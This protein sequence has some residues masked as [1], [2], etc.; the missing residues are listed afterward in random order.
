VPT[1]QRSLRS[2]SGILSQ[3]SPVFDSLAE[4]VGQTRT[5]KSGGASMTA[6]QIAQEWFPGPSNDLRRARIARQINELVEASASAAAAEMQRDCFKDILRLIERCATDCPNEEGKFALGSLGAA[7]LDSGTKGF[8]TDPLPHPG[9][10]Q[11]A[12]LKARQQEHEEH[13]PICCS[14]PD[15]ISKEACARF[16]EIQ[17]ELAQ[18]EAEAEIGD[19]S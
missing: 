14:L 5:G 10:L 19:C 6:E 2:S 7:I 3:A 13:C 9:A 17:A 8:G 18:A 16:K 1:T 12:E 15:D 4:S 11:R